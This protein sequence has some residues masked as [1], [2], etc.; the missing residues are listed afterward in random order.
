MRIFTRRSCNWVIPEFGESY[1]VA[2]RSVPVIL[3][4]LIIAVDQAI[5]AVAF[6]GISW[7]D[8]AIGLLGGI[9][10]FVV[11]LILFPAFAGLVVTFMSDDIAEAVEQ[12]HYPSL[13][14]P[15]KEPL[16]EMLWVA[17]RF[18]AA[19]VALNGLLFLIV[20][21]LL[22][23]SVVFSPLVPVLVYGLNGYL[24]GREYFELAAARRLDARGARDLRKR[25][26]GRIFVAGMLIVALM[27]IPVLNWLMP[28]VAMVFM[29]HLFQ[30]LRA[31]YGGP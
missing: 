26:Q 6:F 15:R 23:I 28:V 29:L 2:S 12:R 18:C 11:G 27:S 30:G 16:W 14:A 25:H 3:A 7:I 19:T 31:R 4:V 13:P 24:V 10:V 20:I 22:L 21:P 5:S 9:G 1:G 8:D 17:M